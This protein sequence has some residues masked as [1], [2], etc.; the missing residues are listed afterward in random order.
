MEVPGRYHHHDTP[1]ATIT[2]AGATRHRQTSQEA[3]MTVGPLEYIIVGFKGNKFDGSIA[4][5]IAKVS[6]QKVIRIVDAVMI[7]KDADGNVAV[8][9]FDNKDDPRFADFA[10]LFADLAGLMTPEDILTLAEEIPADTSALAILFEHRWAV[11]IKDA[12]AAA[13]GFLVGRATVPPE[14]LVELND[15][16]EAALAATAAS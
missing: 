1:G 3:V 13:G 12:M 8:V 9:E 14:V 6:E 10:P 4:R 5:E 7:A 16:L 11:D 2:S 15:E